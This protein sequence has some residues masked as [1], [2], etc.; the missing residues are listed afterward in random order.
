[1]QEFKDFL[2]ERN[3][4]NQY[5]HRQL[6]SALFGI[7]LALPYL[8]TYKDHQLNNSSHNPV[9]DIPNTTN[10][11]DGGVNPKLKDLV[12]R[13]RGMKIERRNKLLVNLL[14]NL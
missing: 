2:N 12:R 6:R 11:L 14:Y 8:F 4:K 9:L 13:H 10:H 1:M 7:K 5:Q 3:D